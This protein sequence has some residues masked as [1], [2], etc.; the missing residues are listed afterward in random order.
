MLRTG[1]VPAFGVD[2]TFPPL[3]F[4]DPKTNK[5]SGYIV[6]VTEMTLADLGVTP[7]WVQTL[8][9]EL[10]AALAA[11]KFDMIGIAA[12]ILPSRALEGY[13]G[14]PALYESNVVLVKKSSCAT[15]SR[16]FSMPGPPCSRGARR[17]QRHDH[18]PQGVVQ[19]VR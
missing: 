4:I 14:V 8:F 2:L 1:G 18:L 10:F 15:T 5:P 11:G 17:L 7:E 13:S 3:Q 12:T 19:G 16:R 9:V 6:E